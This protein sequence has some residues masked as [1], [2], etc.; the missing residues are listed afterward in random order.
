VAGPGDFVSVPPREQGSSARAALRVRLQSEAEG[1][2][3]EALKR[4][5]SDLEQVTAL[6]LEAP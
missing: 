4:K 5:L 3:R 2:E 6:R 1:P